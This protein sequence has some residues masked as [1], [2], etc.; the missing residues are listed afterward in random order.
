MGQLCN[1]GGRGLFGLGSWG[2]FLGGSATTWASEAVGSGG[3]SAE[4][5][6]AVA[7][8]TSVTA[9]SVFLFGFKCLGSQ[10]VG[11]G[12]DFLFGDPQFVLD[13][14]DAVV[15]QSVIVVAPS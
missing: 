5:T 10:G 6:L 12:L 11:S 3:T 2:T 13:V 7:S 1:F 15:V 9:G 14:V 8:V 4:A